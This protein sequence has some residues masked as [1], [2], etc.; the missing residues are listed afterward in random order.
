MGELCAGIGCWMC[1]GGDGGWG[2]GKWH[3]KD[4][5]DD[6]SLTHPVKNDP[7]QHC[8]H[9]Q[10]ALTPGLK[11]NRKGEVKQNITQSVRHERWAA[12]LIIFG[13]LPPCQRARL[14]QHAPYN[15]KLHCAFERGP[16]GSSAPAL[17]AAC[18][19]VGEGGN[20]I[21]RTNKTLLY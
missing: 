9:P 11:G 1:G 19:W 13:E 20:G 4:K 10:V 15:K 21:K 3:K 5:K 14:G 7:I 6:F 18:A 8:C 17:D 16:W 2:G 12:L